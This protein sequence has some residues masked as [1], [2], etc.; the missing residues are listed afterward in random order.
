[1]QLRTQNHMPLTTDSNITNIIF[2]LNGN[3][4][5]GNNEQQYYDG[6][7]HS[8]RT[9]KLEIARELS[10][11][12]RCTLLLAEA[13]V[14]IAG[15]ESR[16][17]MVRWRGVGFSS[18]TFCALSAETHHNNKYCRRQSRYRTPPFFLF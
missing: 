6:R 8:R 12:I 1:L 9:T 17:I 3:I 5:R 10:S 15:G 2:L 16:F 13:V 14:F 18:R 7:R 11:A 4:Y